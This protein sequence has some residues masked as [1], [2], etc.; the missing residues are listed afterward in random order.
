MADRRQLVVG[1]EGMRP[2]RLVAGLDMRRQG[3][4]D[5]WRLLAVVAAAFEGQANRVGMRHTPLEHL[6]DGSIELA[7][8]IALQWPEQG[9]GD[10]AKV[11]A[12][13]GGADQQGP[14]GGAACAKRSVARWRRA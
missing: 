6:V 13:L 8:A 3:E 4:G 2:H 7:G 5:R 11:I 10:A 12:A 9:G 1:L 14:A